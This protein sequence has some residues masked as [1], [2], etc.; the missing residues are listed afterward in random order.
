MY[1]PLL[2]QDRGTVMHRNPHVRRT[3]GANMSRM[4]EA[5]GLFGVH[6]G[7][8]KGVCRGEIPNRPSVSQ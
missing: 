3:E 2:W 6:A 7:R 4:V 8:A 5:K 1:L